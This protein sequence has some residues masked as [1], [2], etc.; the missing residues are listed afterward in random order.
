M[1]N[2]MALKSNAYAWASSTS[3]SD[4][5]LTSEDKNASMIIIDN[6]TAYPVA[7]TSGATSA[8][9]ALPTSA[10]VPVACKVVN[11]GQVQAYNKKVGDG[12]ISLI[13]GTADSGKYVYIY[14]GSGD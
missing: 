14:V 9:A 8:T 12:V 11:A 7:V 5:T 1:D 2:P 13:Q 4:V 6:Q 3:E 10:S